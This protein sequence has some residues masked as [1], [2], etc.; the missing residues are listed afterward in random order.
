[1][2]V[3]AYRHE[4]DDAAVGRMLLDAYR[5]GPVFDPWLHPRWEYMH[6]HPL[7]WGLDLA[8]FGVAE[9]Q[10]EIQGIV[11]FEH[12]PAVCYLQRRPGTDHVIEPLLDWASDH[13]G[14]ESPTFGRDVLGLYVPEFDTALRSALAVRG[15]VEHPEHREPNA[16]LQGLAELE[17]P[18]P[19]GYR[20]TSVADENDLARIDRL[21]WRGFGHDGPWPSSG[22]EGR[23]FTQSAPNF[24]PELTIVAVDARGEHAAFCGVWVVPQHRLA[25]VEPVATDP[26]HRRRGAGRAVVLEALRRAGVTGADVAWVGADMPFYRALGFE[27]MFAS[28][29]WVVPRAPGA[30][31]PPGTTRAS[32]TAGA[33]ADRAGS[34]Q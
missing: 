19:A 18:V 21:L 30:A 20:L 26:D 1:M 10:G 7:I 12:D 8:R 33:P 14:G 6:F 28:T 22:V 11:H 34:L 23:R 4:A 3:R 15:A 16:R 13:L 27:P 5:P 29:L 9:E 24:R 31:G 32:T 2:H 17:P 25:Y